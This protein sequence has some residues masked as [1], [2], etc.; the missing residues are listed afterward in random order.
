MRKFAEALKNAL[1]KDKRKK[2][3]RGATGQEEPYERPRGKEVRETQDDKMRRMVDESNK[4]RIRKNRK[5]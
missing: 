4:A 1:K 5:K 2:L 3:I